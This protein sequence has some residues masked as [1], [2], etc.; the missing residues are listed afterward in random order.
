MHDKKKMDTDSIAVLV[1]PALPKI[2]QF[3][4]SRKSFHIHGITTILK[5]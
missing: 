1:Y 3:R 5:S 4:L 2:V